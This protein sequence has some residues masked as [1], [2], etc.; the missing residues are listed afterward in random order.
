MTTSGEQQGPEEREAQLSTLRKRMAKAARRRDLD[1]YAELKAEH[2]R[3][4]DEHVMA[5]HAE[6]KAAMR[7]Q[8]AR[9]RAQVAAEPSGRWR[10]PRG[11]G[12]SPLAAQRAR[13]GGPR[14]EA[15]MPAGGLRPWRRGGGPMSEQIWR[16]GRRPGR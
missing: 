15:S 12:V 7:A 8:K 3:L 6:M 4:K 5:S 16:P 13:G 10:L 2:D 9:E 14:V 1:R 11:F